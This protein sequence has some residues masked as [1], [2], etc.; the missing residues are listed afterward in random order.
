LACDLQTC[1][2]EELARQSQAGSLAA[3]EGLVY[4]Y[5]G[6]VYGFVTTLCGNCADARDVTQDTFVR[7]FQAMAQFDCRRDFAPWLFTIARRKCIDH[8]RAAPPATHEPM[9]ELPDHN[10]PAE[11][12]ARQQ[13]RQSLWQ[14]ARRRLPAVQFQALWLRYVEELS[15]PAIAQVLRKTQTH[16]KVL[17][18]RGRVT[19]GRA[20]K[21]AEMS[22]RMA[23]RTL[24]PLAR[25]QEPRRVP[26]G[27]QRPG[28][29]GR[30][31]GTFCRAAVGS[32]PEGARKGRV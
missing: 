18:F 5:E 1:S 10:D 12:L 19:L 3:F 31:V 32:Q 23:E 22:G 15:V 2:D 21:A 20:L 25:A 27:A 24:T 6:R 11:L 13:E 8:Q 16:I 7:A 14:L 28:R 30:S 26:L 9:P 4:R 17:L 29:I